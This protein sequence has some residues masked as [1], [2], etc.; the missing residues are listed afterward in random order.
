MTK[1]TIRLLIVLSIMVCGVL[2]FPSPLKI[3]LERLIL[4]H[5]IEA[6]QNAINE[7]EVLLQKIVSNPKVF[8]KKNRH[9]RLYK[10][11]HDS[12]VF[13]SS[14]DVPISLN[15][16]EYSFY[17]PLIHLKNGWYLAQKNKINDTL[18]VA[19]YR[20]QSSYEFEN[21]YLKTE[22]SKDLPDFPKSSLGLQKI[23]D[24]SFPIQTFGKNMVFYLTPESN[25][26]TGILDLNQLV[27]WL[28]MIG[29]FAL[30]WISLNINPSRAYSILGAFGLLRILMLYFEFP[31]QISPHGL[32][33]PAVFFSSWW[34]PTLGD[35]VLHAF[36]VVGI[37]YVHT[38]RPFPR[39]VLFMLVFILG[40]VNLMLTPE[41]ILN[42]SLELSIQNIAAFG[43]LEYITYALIILFLLGY[44]F[45]FRSLYQ[46]LKN[47]WPIL[48]LS[49]PLIGLF[50]NNLQ[51]I[52]TFIIASVIYAVFLSIKRMWPS[53]PFWFHG[54]ILV[55]GLVGVSFLSVLMFGALRERQ[56]NEMSFLVEDQKNQHD[57]SLELNMQEHRTNLEHY[58]SKTI[59]DI[60]PQDIDIDEINRDLL[61][62][63]LA[64]HQNHYEVKISICYGSN[65]EHIISTTSKKSYTYFEN[66][67]K[68]NGQPT[69]CPELSFIENSGVHEDYIFSFILKDLRY[70]DQYKIYLSFKRI[71]LTDRVGFTDIL[72]NKSSADYIRYYKYSFATYENETLTHSSGSFIYPRSEENLKSPAYHEFKHSTFQD[73]HKTYVASVKKPNFYDFI[74]LCSYL[75][76]FYFILINTGLLLFYF[77]SFRTYIQ[78][79]YGKVQ[80]TLFV[81]FFVVLVISVTA[82]YH[83][84]VGRI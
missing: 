21:D 84:F 1:N 5:H 81:L 3:K 50:F 8:S 36:L 22:F 12:L 37:C 23:S 19:L 6:F 32:F 24:R 47:P 43:V 27:V 67:L 15:A 41:L 75:F 76:F 53:K 38:L 45:L 51:N 44:F 42:S 9:V 83:Y 74:T 72:Q 73:Q 39:I 52:I 65:F 79:L 13:W 59:F 28:M 20:I 25:L 10:Y 35:L 49:I 62:L 82:T 68:N 61:N 7:K 30:G 18:F 70:P 26:C 16:N 60:S 4:E 14:N 48:I 69:I 55:L 58:F 54:E 66:I 71:G 80:F 2:F 57:L 64:K 63:Y 17:S 31:H 11:V 34:A 77:P 46:N 56:K 29:I 40:A 78:S 33:D